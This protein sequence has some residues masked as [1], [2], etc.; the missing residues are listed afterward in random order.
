VFA[1]QV[2]D[3]RENVMEVRVL[4]SASDSGKLFDLR[5]DL[6]EMLIGFLQRDYPNALPHQRVVIAEGAIPMSGGRPN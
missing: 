4:V 1:V 5:A 6:R 3:F 2:T